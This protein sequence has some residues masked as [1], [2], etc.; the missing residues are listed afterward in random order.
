MFTFLCCN[1][2]DSTT[3]SS[4][5]FSLLFILFFLF[6]VVLFLPKRINLLAS[7]TLTFCPL[8]SHEH[9]ERPKDV[10]GRFAR[11]NKPIRLHRSSCSSYRRWNG[12]EISSFVFAF[13]TL[14]P[15]ASHPLPS[16][17]FQSY[18]T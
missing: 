4:L 7:H 15:V 12:C 6:S 8:V 11:P 10:F 13:S 9:R 2:H 17:R 3:I 14:G 1:H 16:F 18:D 5:A